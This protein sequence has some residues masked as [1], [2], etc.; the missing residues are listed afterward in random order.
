MNMTAWHPALAL[1]LLLSS[2]E[3]SLAAPGT[4][5]QVSGTG[6]YYQL[7]LPLVW[8]A[9]SQHPDLRDVRIVNAQGQSLPYAWVDTPS[10]APIEQQTTVS[11]FKWNGPLQPAASDPKAAPSASPTSP[12][13]PIWIMDLRRAPGQLQRLEVA[14]PT[15]APGLFAVA[16]ESSPDLQHWT[17]L[18]ESVQLASLT[19]GGQTLHQQTIELG[20]IGP[21]YVRLRLLPGSPAPRMGEA[22]LTT[23]QTGVATPVLSWSGPIKASSC[24]ERFC[25]YALPSHVAIGRIKMLLDEPN[26]LMRLQ[27]QGRALDDSGATQAQADEPPHRHRG[28]RERLHALRHKRHDEPARTKPASEEA[29]WRWIGEG[30]VH[31]IDQAGQPLRSDELPVDQGRYRT[32]RVSAAE[33][34]AGWTK[35]PPAIEVASGLRTLVFLA[36]GA[37]PYQLQWA[38]GDAAEVA[39]PMSELMVGGATV[40]T[41][42]QGRAT[43]PAQVIVA[44][45]VSTSAAP[46]G[47]EAVSTASA[48]GSNKGLLPSAWWLWAA[49]LLGLG[50]MA[51]MA[52]SVLSSRSPDAAKAD[53]SNPSGP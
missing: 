45:G 32:L 50:L 44:S 24:T 46:K 22:V 21:S 47:P 6:P 7:A 49:L 16:V 19:H 41:S 52:R 3:P 14:L 33:G 20:G 42:W 2:F 43:L 11:L 25:D 15:D 13:W 38:A 31:W 23:S 10:P 18:Q 9:R 39:L 4:A 29:G 37:Q 17:T 5:L 12:S 27:L 40:P 53:D 51:Y 30:D 34:N 48:Q 36:K 8:Q 28:L 26:T 1:T 35:R